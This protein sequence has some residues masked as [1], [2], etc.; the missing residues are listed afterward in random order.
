M[1]VNLEIQGMTCAHCAKHVEEALTAVPGVQK[2]KVN[3][4]KEEAKVSAEDHL[5]IATLLSA[6][7]AAGY[8]AK[9]KE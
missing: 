6:V 2:A 8:S 5:E 4:K 3:L 1:K 7:D 9:V